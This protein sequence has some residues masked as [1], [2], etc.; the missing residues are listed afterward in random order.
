MPNLARTV[1]VIALLLCIA[2]AAFYYPLLPD[3]VASHFGVSG[4]PD[5]WTDKDSFMK[6][7]IGVIVFTA[8]LFPGIGFIL[9]RTP[10]SLM[11]LPNKDYWLAPERRQGTID[12]VSRQFLLFGSATLLLL[13]HIFHQSF[14]VHLGIAQQLEHPIASIG[15]YLIFSLFWTIGLLLRFMRRP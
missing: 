2:H 5:A 14:R 12:L 1:F 9:R 4:Q 11:N 8:A 3:R 15:A 6:I 10:V 13:L 7:Y